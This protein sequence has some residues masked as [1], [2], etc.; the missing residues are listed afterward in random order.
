MSKVRE[1][2][3]SAWLLPD[4][5]KRIDHRLRHDMRRFDDADEV[6]LVVVGCRCRRLD[7][8]PAAGPRGMEGRGDGCRAVL[9][10]GH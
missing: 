1:R 4:D 9:G 3:G 6:D 10:P 5:G 7:A 2:N 8:D